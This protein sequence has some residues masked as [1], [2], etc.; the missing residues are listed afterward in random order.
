MTPRYVLYARTSS[1]NQKKDETIATQ[2]DAAREWSERSGRP[3]AARYLDDGVSSKIPFAERAGGAHL[4]ADAR[5][6]RLTH[7]LIYNFR[8][9]GRDQLDTLQTL[10][11]LTA[12]GVTVQSICEPMPEGSEHDIGGL[13]AGVLTSFAQYDWIQLRRLL[14]AGKERWA[15]AGYWPGGP[16]PFGYWVAGERRKRLA[17]ADLELRVVRRIGEMYLSG[18]YSQHAIADI[19]NAE[20]Q[21]TPKG[22]REGGALHYRW[23][24]SLISA[25]LRDTLYA[26]HLRWRGKTIGFDPELAVFTADEWAQLRRVTLSKTVNAARN[27]KR[28]YLLRGL[29]KCGVSGCGK[30][31]CGWRGGGGARRGPE[32]GVI[33]YRCCSR[34]TK[35]QRCGAKDVNGTWVEAEVWAWCQRALSRPGEYLADLRETLLARAREVGDPTDEIKRLQAVRAEGRA[36]RARAL[37]MIVRG[38]MDERDAVPILD[39]LEREAEALEEEI[40]RHEETRRRAREQDRI[41]DEQRRLLA[42]MARDRNTEDPRRRRRII[43]SL[44]TRVIVYHERGAPAPVIH[45]ERRM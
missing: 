2:L 23:T 7:L 29:I 3:L 19:L 31:M 13:M 18:A 35:G 37:D 9:L 16:P 39:R 42:E 1:E 6:G 27:S 4:L 40:N 22:M 34:Y 5:E 10:R 43:E 24:S 17:R 14:T 41:L 12:L 33:Y 32:Q 11:A 21:P 15:G 30:S 25:L 38:L 8:R 26:G 20:A 36:A 28:E 44:L 45:I